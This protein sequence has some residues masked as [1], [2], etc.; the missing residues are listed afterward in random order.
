M[1]KVVVPP[2]AYFKIIVS[3]NHGLHVFRRNLQSC[4]AT[5]HLKFSVVS[6][7]LSLILQTVWQHVTAAHSSSIA[8]WRECLT[9][10]HGCC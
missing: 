10:T 4:V 7:C 9:S 8:S 6:I 1:F 2:Y 5:Q 3:F